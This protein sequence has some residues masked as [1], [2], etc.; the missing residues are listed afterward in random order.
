MDKRREV[1]DLRSLVEDIRRQTANWPS[2]MRAPEPGT[3]PK[4]ERIISGPSP[5][6]QNDHSTPG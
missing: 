3:D 4:W 2:S 1:Q 6:S 5:T